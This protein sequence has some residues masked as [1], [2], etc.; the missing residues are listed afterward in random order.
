MEAAGGDKRGGETG[1][2]SCGKN[3][4]FAPGSTT[5]G[6]AYVAEKDVNCFFR[7]QFENSDFYC[8]VVSYVDINTESASS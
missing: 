7:I 1:G 8:R 4:R 5:Q 2:K 3:V 6:G